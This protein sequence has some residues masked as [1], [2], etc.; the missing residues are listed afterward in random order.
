LLRAGTA[1]AVLLEPMQAML[2][3]VSTRRLPVLPV[4]GAGAAGRRAR[5]LSQPERRRLE[6]DLQSLARFIEVYCRHRHADVSKRP[7]ELKHHDIAALTGRPVHL[8]PD[9]TRLITH[10]FTKRSNCPLRPKPQCKHCPSHCYHPTYRKKIQEVM[11]FSGMKILMSGRLDY[12]L[13]L[14]F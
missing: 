6:R 10:A 13:H 8:C 14:L 1:L 9:C 3:F 11:R 7:V 4:S 12:L 2:N 5:A